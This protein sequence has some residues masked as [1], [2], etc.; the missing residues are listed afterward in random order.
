MVRSVLL[1]ALVLLSVDAGE[2]EE[3]KDVVN[4]VMASTRSGLTAD[5]VSSVVG[6]CVVGVEAVVL[7]SGVVLDVDDIGTAG[8]LK[9]EI[10]KDDVDVMAVLVGMNGGTMAGLM[11]KSK[12]N[13]C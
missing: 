13:I 10:A 5:E 2:L 1:G 4:V 6:M 7:D 11:P 8:T 9:V 12:H 3:D